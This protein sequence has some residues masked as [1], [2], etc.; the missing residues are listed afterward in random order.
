MSQTFIKG[1]LILTIATFISK[2]LGSI[3]Q[4]PLQNIAGDDVLGIF[5][6]VYP[7]YMIALILSVAG[8]PIAISKLISEAQA[9]GEKQT[10]SHIFSTA[11][12]LGSSLG[13]IA[14]LVL[15]GF[16]NQIALALGGSF[17]KPAVQIVA[18]TLIIAPYMAVYRGY[19]QGFGDMRPTAISQVLEQ[20]I[21]VALIIG[22]AYFLVQRNAD[23][24]T[25]GGGIMI[26]SSIGALISLIY[27]KM[28]LLK[29]KERPIKTEAYTLAIFKKWAKKI[30][31]LSI[32]IAIGTLTMALLNLIDSLTLPHALRWKGFSELEIQELFGVYGRGLSLVQI[33]VVFS[34]AIILPLIPS[35]SKAMVKN[36]ITKTNQYIEKSLNLAHLVSWPAAIGLLALALPINLAL[37]TDLKGSLT[38]AVIGFSALF[39]SYSVLTTGILQGLNKEDL[40]AWLIVFAAVMKAILNLW[41]VS[42]YSIFGA[43][44]MTLITYFTVVAT[45]LIIIYR[46][47][48]FSL[49]LKKLFIIASAS[50]IMGGVIYLPL[51]F[52]TIAD[53]SRLSAVIY[54]MIMIPI[55]AVIYA[56]IV[57]IGK[58]IDKEE[59][60]AIP[61]AGRFLKVKEQDKN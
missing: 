58:G 2:L 6:L 55:G 48:K 45:N 29:A 3:F 59:L 53:W 34:S 33:T 47:T 25:I 27:L 12:I 30:L 8:I 38:F 61:G 36:D 21:R 23:N 9:V 10:I 26:G 50:M 13:A 1:T 18:I 5:R 7:V 52:F 19:F 17:T 60:A 37:F 35:I 39:T 24:P 43:A 22:V 28:K 31:K 40:A 14:F 11:S 41:L 44:I 16:S 20:F 51:G 4:V 56:L 15:F 46:E 54:L 42:S 49:N 32:P 57:I